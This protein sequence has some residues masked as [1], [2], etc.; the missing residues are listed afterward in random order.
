MFARHLINDELKLFIRQAVE[1]KID[2]RKSSISHA[3]KIYLS[4]MLI[5]YLHGCRSFYT[6]HKIQDEDSMN[7]MIM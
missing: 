6:W 5:S 4:E 7:G 1:R 2:I 3:V